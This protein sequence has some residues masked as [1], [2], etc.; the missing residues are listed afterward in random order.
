M[1]SSMATTFTI[2]IDYDASA[3]RLLELLTDPAFH[4]RRALAFGARSAKATRRV[5]PD[6]TVVLVC[7]VERSDRRIAGFADRSE[8]TVRFAGGGPLAT[9]THRQFGVEDRASVGGTVEIRARGPGR[10]QYVNV[11]TIA[12]DVPMFGRRIEKKIKEV[13]ESGV[14]QEAN[15]TRRALAASVAAA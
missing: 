11:A 12:V 6:G 15:Y 1:G 2:R 13:I 7:E 4:E 9:W 5:E 8:M 3:E 10:S 14:E